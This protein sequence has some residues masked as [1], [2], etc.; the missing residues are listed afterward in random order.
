M[1]FNINRILRGIY[2]DELFLSTKPKIALD[3]TPNAGTSWHEDF[4]LIGWEDI[5]PWDDF[6]EETIDLLFD[7]ELRTPLGN[8]R[9]ADKV[10]HVDSLAKDEGYKVETENDIDKMF[11]SCLQNLLLKT[12]N[13]YG[14]VVR[15]KMGKSDIQKFRLEWEKTPI[16]PEKKENPEKKKTS[17][18]KGPDWP[19]FTTPLAKKEKKGKEARHEIFMFGDAK[20]HHVFDPE[21]LSEKLKYDGAK[22]E[23]TMGQMGMY[24]YWGKTRYAYVITS[25]TL[26]VFRFFLI[27]KEDN[28][29][30]RMGAEYK[31]F[32]W[33]DNWK[34]I[35][36]A[37]WALAMLSMK[38]DEREVVTRQEMLPISTWRARA[39]PHPKKH[40]GE[41][42]K[43]QLSKKQEHDAYDSLRSV[44][45][46]RIKK[47]S[48]R[49]G[50][51]KTETLG[52]AGLS[53]PVSS[54]GRDGAR[55]GFLS[56]ADKLQFRGSIVKISEKLS[57]RHSEED[58]GWLA[59]TVIDIFRSKTSRQLD[60]VARDSKA[61][62]AKGTRVVSPDKASTAILGQSKKRKLEILGSSPSSARENK[63]HHRRENSPTK[64]ETR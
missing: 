52:N 54:V 7:E 10:M 56:S 44:K 30:I 51:K 35:P 62:K 50:T 6:S 32:S 28:G 14:N 61:R 40:E 24:A 4:A 19:L 27:S 45:G 57:E 18:K 31:S 58:I 17:T 43:E 64:P 36:K 11:G 15:R 48:G 33:D 5:S 13:F 9:V 37:I 16:Y 63:I 12:I 25:K 42:D 53:N 20:R 59:E 8:W 60:T 3:E 49:L 38:D 22:L 29:D 1:E 39:L 21:K 2:C 46:G 41:S 55:E 23:N 34:M 47:P 26:T